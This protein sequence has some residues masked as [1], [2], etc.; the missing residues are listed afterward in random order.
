ME[1]LK[2]MAL[3]INE[4]QIG[5]ADKLL[6]MLTP[7][8]GRLVVS[9]KGVQ[10]L[11]SRHMASCQLFCYSNFV[12]RKSKKYYYISDSDTEECFFNIRF[13]IEKVALATYMCDVACDLAL[14]DVGD[15][16]L[17]RLMLNSLYALSAKKNLSLD[18]IKAAFEF[19]AAVQGGFMPIL[20]SC[21]V[22][23]KEPIDDNIV[24]DVMNGMFRCSE[25]TRLV[26]KEGIDPSGTAEI[27]HKINSTVLTALRFIATAPITKFLSFSIPAEDMEL[28]ARFAESYLL[29]HLEHSF[30][31]LK[32]FKDIRINGI[33][34]E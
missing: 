34:Y 4:K 27:Y 14:E 9:G 21:G 8:H 16:E 13:D 15:P 11:R 25:C 23:G 7:E 33:D 20:D 29:S 22:C 17:L 32:Y 24:F 28:L 26:A 6:T 3:V 10:S 2:T 30:S 12:F 18:H 5:E 31:S 19:R 1:E